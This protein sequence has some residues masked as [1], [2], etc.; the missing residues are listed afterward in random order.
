MSTRYRTGRQSL[1][2]Q[3]RLKAVRALR[4]KRQ[5]CHICGGYIDLTL[6][7]PHKRSFS[8]DEIV[9]RSRGGSSIDLRNLLSSHLGCNSS[10]GVKPIAVARAQARR[11]PRWQSRAW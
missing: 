11:A 9:P 4:A 5:P 2:S 6:K 1:S 8:A 7:A 3:A 10:R